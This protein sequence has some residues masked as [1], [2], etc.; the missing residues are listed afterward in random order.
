MLGEQGKQIIIKEALANGRLLENNNYP[1]YHDLYRHL[2][3]LSA[4]HGVT[5]DAIA[6]RFVM[7][8]LNPTIVLS[9]AATIEQL[10]SNLKA[11]SFQSSPNELESLQEFRIE[12]G[13][14]WTERKQLEWN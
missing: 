5:Q 11:R 14:Y 8:S 1:H 13:T 2:E 10:D 4:A 7:D 6:L 9:G 12:P 3:E